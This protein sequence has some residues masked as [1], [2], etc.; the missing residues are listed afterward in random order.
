MIKITK[1]REPRI[2]EKY[3]MQHGAIVNNRINF[4]KTIKRF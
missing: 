4:Q 3:R 1:A 2:L